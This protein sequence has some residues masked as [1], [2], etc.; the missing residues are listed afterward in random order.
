[1]KE[2]IYT[3]KKEIAEGVILFGFIGALVFC[4]FVRTVFVD[5]KRLLNFRNNQK[6]ELN[7]ERLY[8]K[9]MP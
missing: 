2:Y 4:L 9:I 3:G 6:V 1:M 8:E 7:D 5:N